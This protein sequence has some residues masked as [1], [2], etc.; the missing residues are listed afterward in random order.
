MLI[1]IGI[2]LIVYGY[3]SFKYSERWAQNARERAARTQFPDWFPLLIRAGG[4]LF[5]ITGIL[6]L[7]ADA[8]L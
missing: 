2:A 8:L 4:I 5:I 1:V 6:L 3:F 7:L